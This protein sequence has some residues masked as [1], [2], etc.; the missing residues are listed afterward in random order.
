M[1]GIKH[2]TA[3]DFVVVAGYFAAIILIGLYVAR[4][5]RHT[6]DYFVAGAG[7]PWWLGAIS[8]WMAGFS[9]LAFV[10]YSEI[11]YKYG[12]TALTLYW[13]SVPCMLIGAFLFVGRWR[14][15]RMMSPIGFVEARFSPALRQV[16]V[17]TGF[18]LRFI[19]NSIKIY[20]TAIFIVAAISSDAIDMTRAIW[21]TGIVIIAFS[22]MGGQWSVLVTDFVQFIIKVLAAVIIFFVALHEVGGVGSFLSRMP[23][24]FKLVLHPPYDLYQYLT[25]IVLVFF[26][27]NAGWAMIQKYNCVRSESDARKVVIGVALWNLVL[28]VILFAPAMFA[29]VVIPDIPNARFSYAYISLKTLPVGMMGVMIAALLSATLATLSNEYSTLSSVFTNDFYAKKIRPGASQKHFIGVGRVSVV[30]IGLFTTLLAVLLQQIQGMNLFD[31]MVKAFTAFAPAIMAPLLGGILIRRINSRGALAGIVGGFVSGSVLLALNIIL[32]GM[33]R[34]QFMTNPKLNYWLNQGWSSTSII[35]NFSVTIGG[36]FLGSLFGKT[37]DEEKART[38]DFFLRLKE[39]YVC[40]TDPDR[41]SPF[42]AIGIVVILMGIG[43]TAVSFAVKYLYPQPGWFGI[44]M[45]ASGI[46]L[47]VGVLIWLLARRKPSNLKR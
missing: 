41:K 12:F 20:A 43:L 33:Y 47:G 28:P 1:E 40:E 19:D 45:T 15:A 35:I 13:V 6:K 29:R 32:V 10:M 42:P 24:D 8:L 21:I 18:P 34:D 25:W 46:L 38:D 36:L 2:L 14:R 30:A 39:T 7:I 5:V 44:N 26:S 3:L 37:S 31:I 22:F 23:A 11:G 17:W 16:F 9:A 4:Y 27:L